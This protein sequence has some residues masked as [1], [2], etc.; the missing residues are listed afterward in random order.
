VQ[1][2]PAFDLI[3]PEYGPAG[4]TFEASNWAMSAPAFAP[5]RDEIWFTDA[6]QGF[7]AVRLTNGA[8][9]EFVRPAVASFAGSAPAPTAAPTPAPTPGAI[10]LPITGAA[11]WLQAIGALMLCGSLTLTNRRR[12]DHEAGS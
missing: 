8:W 10:P 12:S 7:Y 3:A 1:P 4:I 2:R 5:E 6:F 9:P 11:V